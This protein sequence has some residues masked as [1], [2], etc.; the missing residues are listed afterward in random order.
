MRPPR[1]GVRSVARTAIAALRGAA[2]PVVIFG[3]ADAAAAWTRARGAGYWALFVAL[4]LL[5]CG[6][7]S[8]ALDAIRTGSASLLRLLDGFARVHLVLFALVVSA[9]QAWLAIGLVQ[10]AVQL[11]KVTVWP[12]P[13]Y[14]ISPF[15][16]YLMRWVNVLAR[17]ATEFI[18][19]WGLPRMAIGVCTVMGSAPLPEREVAGQVRRL[20][21]GNA[22]RWMLLLTVL[23]F[24]DSLAKL[25]TPAGLI[26]SAPLGVVIIAAAYLDLNSKFTY[27]PEAQSQAPSAAEVSVS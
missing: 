16:P 7:L 15:D 26:L 12:H 5:R 23:G 3:F 6:C 8:L 21:H 4:T 13:G 24:L 1:F 9:W 10:G 25:G 27:G 14:D 11:F 19:I 17:L 2:G 20:W 22:L 18:L